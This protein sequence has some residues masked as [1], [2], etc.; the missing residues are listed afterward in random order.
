ML[1]VEISD[2]STP[3][4]QF[5]YPARSAF[6]PGNEALGVSV[7]VLAQCD[8]LVHV[9]QW[10]GQQ[11]SLNVAV[12]TAVLMSDY[13]RQNGGQ[14]GLRRGS[15]FVQHGTSDE[16][17]HVQANGSVRQ[18]AQESREQKGPHTE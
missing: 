4:H 14:P 7:D 1:A 13:M 17:I 11:S 18:N 15:K 5:R 12:A 10:G 2:A 3:S 8:A 16:S 6:L 9:E